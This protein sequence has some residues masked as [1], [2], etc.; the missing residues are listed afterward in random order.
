MRTLVLFSL[1]LLIGCPGTPKDTDTGPDAPSDQ[2]RDGTPDDEDCSPQNPAIH[3]DATEVC[4]TIDNNCDG[5][6]DEGVT[7]PFYADSDNDGFGDP[8]STKDACSTPTGY[9][10]NSDDCDDSDAAYNPGATED[11]CADPNDYNCDGSTGYTDADGDGTAACEDCNDNDAAINPGGTEL[12]NGKDDNCDG[13]TDGPDAADAPAWYTDSDGDGFGVEANPIRSCDQPAGTASTFGDCNDSDSAYNPG[14]SESDC[15]DP[16]DYNCDGSS[17]YDDADSDGYPACQ[18]CNDGEADQNPGATEVCN[19]ADDNC[20]GATD[21]DSAADN[22]ADNFG[23]PNVAW[24]A[25]NQ[26]TGYV[27]DNLDCDDTSADVSPDATEVCNGTDDNCDGSTDEDSAADAPTWYADADGDAYG[28]PNV[29]WTTCT[30]PS[31]YVADNLDCDDTSTD[32]SP[33]A[34]ELCNGIDDNCDG[35]TDEDS[36]ADA[37]NW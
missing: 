37:H 31:G 26:P 12:C 3:K 23:D 20:D 24:P 1:S 29:G 21:E 5:T 6:V 27:A 34:T 35:S 33:A 7:T 30:Q 22:D 15:T 14:A 25:C 32:V 18:D 9:S 17:G 8:S 28:D 2:D 13:T 19:G 11:N 16:N 4:D 10:D 36:A